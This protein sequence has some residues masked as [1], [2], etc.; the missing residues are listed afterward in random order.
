[1]STGLPW[2]YPPFP[3]SCPFR[4]AIAAPGSPPSQSPPCR[5]PAAGSSNGLTAP[6]SGTVPEPSQIVGEY[7]YTAMRLQCLGY[8]SLVRGVRSGTPFPPVGPVAAPCGSPAVPHLH[9]YYEAVQTAPQPS[10]PAS[11]LPWRHGT[12]QTK[13]TYGVRGDGEFSWVPGESVGSMP[14][15]RDSGDPGPTSHYGRRQIL[16]SAA[17]TASASQRTRFRS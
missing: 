6:R 10:T 2:L 1:M 15:A 11:G 3:A 4:S 13:A 17:L 7:G 12:S 8:G 5:F 16:P 14:R 9:R